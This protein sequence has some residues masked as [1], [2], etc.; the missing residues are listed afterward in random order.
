VGTQ[1]NSLGTGRKDTSEKEEKEETGIPSPTPQPGIWMES[2]WGEVASGLSS[3]LGVPSF[4]R[5]CVC[6]HAHRDKAHV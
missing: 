1:S 2:G 3:A 4:Q 5:L 6:T